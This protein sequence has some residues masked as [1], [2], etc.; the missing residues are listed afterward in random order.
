MTEAESNV[1]A[2]WDRVAEGAN[3]ALLG[4]RSP[5]EA[6]EGLAAVHVDCAHSRGG[7][8]LVRE[9]L[10]R[11]AGSLGGHAARWL[12]E[13]VRTR[14]GLGRRL[15]DEAPERVWGQALRAALVELARSTRRPAALVFESVDEAPDDVCRLLGELAALAP[16]LGVPVLLAFGSA[17][18]EGA[19]PRAL[20]EELREREGERVIHRAVAQEP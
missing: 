17:E 1:A 7:L 9:L 8:A 18:P 15:L 4:A 3:A 13:A 10:V 19:G 14:G 20:L 11:L 12:P 5:G 6:P 16:E 2:A